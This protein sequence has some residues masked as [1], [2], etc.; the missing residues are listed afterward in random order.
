MLRSEALVLDQKRKNV[1]EKLNA[2]EQD[3][4]S[5]ITLMTRIRDWGVWDIN[6]LTLNPRTYYQIFGLYPGL[7]G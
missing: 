6:G 5:L 3:H 2:L 7:P 1:Q 4:T